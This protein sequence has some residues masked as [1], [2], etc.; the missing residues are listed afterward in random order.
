MDTAILVYNGN[1][2][3]GV[4]HITKFIQDMPASEHSITTVDAQPILDISAGR[5]LLIQISG[6]VKYEN[7]KQSQAFQQSFLITAQDSKWKI[8]SDTFRL[9]NGIYG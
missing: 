3:A 9:Q 7:Q 5:S 2:I 6:T 1:G 8:V 4:E